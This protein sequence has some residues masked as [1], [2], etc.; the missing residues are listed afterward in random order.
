MSGSRILL[1]RPSGLHRSRQDDLGPEV[2]RH[3][4]REMFFHGGQ[5]PPLTSHDTS[6]REE[7]PYGQYIR[8]AKLPTHGSDTGFLRMR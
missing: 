3:C 5:V 7:P 4:P 2:A 8:L 1:F 6:G